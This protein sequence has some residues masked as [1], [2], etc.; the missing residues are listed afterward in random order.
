MGRRRRRCPPSPAPG[1]THTSRSA[2]AGNGGDGKVHRLVSNSDGGLSCVC[3]IVARG[4]DMVSLE[5]AKNCHKDND[6]TQ[7][8]EVQAQSMAHA[9]PWSDGPVS[10]EE[11]TRRENAQLGGTRVTNPC[12]R[13]NDMQQAQ[14]EVERQARKDAEELCRPDAPDQGRGQKLL[15]GLEL[16]FRKMPALR[17][18]M[19]RVASHIRL[20]AIRIY[21]LSV[22][23][24]RVCW[25]MAARR[26][27]YAL[28]SRNMVVL[29]LGIIELVL[30]QLV[31]VEEGDGRLVEE[32]TQ[33]NN[34]RKD[35]ERALAQLSQVQEDQNVGNQA[36]TELLSAVHFISKWK[37]GEELFA[38]T[39]SDFGMSHPN[40]LPDARRNSPGEFGKSVASDPG[41][42]SEKLRVSLK[43]V[44]KMIPMDT[45]TKEVASYQLQVPA[46]MQRANLEGLPRDV[47]AT[48][49]VA[50]SALK[51]K[52]DDPTHDLRRHW[53]RP[54]HIA[55][56]TIDDFISRLGECI[57][58]PPELSEAEK[59]AE[60]AR[61]QVFG[62]E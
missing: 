8:G 41:D 39:P 45:A 57:E 46:V 19:P 23:H 58:L 48:A 49:I 21:Q 2:T 28:S 54:L 44:V 11:R 33:G 60:Q 13:K 26:C 16:A 62:M 61:D 31:G 10:K 1:H 37:P 42:T 38:C 22:R 17:D 55:M 18:D 56:S 34:T 32:I 7:V 27:T 29:T 25:C 47:V 43:A 36:R 6:P 5:R 3:G 12:A 15:D 59:E 24:E 4:V 20:E 53:F 14:R 52:K 51:Q 50:A 40:W 30:S 9:A 35:I